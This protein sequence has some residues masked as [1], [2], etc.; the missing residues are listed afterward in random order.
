MAR[1]VPLG[2]GVQLGSRRRLR[3]P[4]DQP[5]NR[6]VLQGPPPSGSGRRQRPST[7]LVE[8]DV[9]SLGCVGDG[10]ADR[11]KRARARLGDASIGGAGRARAAAGP[12][13]NQDRR[14]IRL[15]SVAGGQSRCRAGGG[16]TGNTGPRLAGRPLVADPRLRPDVRTRECAGSSHEPG[17][18]TIPGWTASF[19]SRISASGVGGAFRPRAHRGRSRAGESRAPRRG[20]DVAGGES[21]SGGDDSSLGSR[22]GGGRSTGPRAST[23]SG[24]RRTAGGGRCPRRN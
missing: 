13:G 6:P 15:R 11:R 16:R 14:C 8:A 7:R 2:A 18:R 24:R 9:R 10:C 5:P 23:S 19:G 21:S 22:S 1:D 4:P 3:S 12:A 20:G 17:G